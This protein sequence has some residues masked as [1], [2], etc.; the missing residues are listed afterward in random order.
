M[1]KDSISGA[2]L[3]WQVTPVKL[4]MEI[5]EDLALHGTNV[6]HPAK[7]VKHT[8][9]SVQHCKLWKP[10]IMAYSYANPSNICNAC[11]RKLSQKQK[12]IPSRMRYHKNRS[13]FLCQSVQHKCVRC[14]C[15]S[16]A[17]QNLRE[18][19]WCITVTVTCRRPFSDMKL[20][21]VHGKMSPQIC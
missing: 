11:D 10:D 20:S 1:Q 14:K 5:G 18:L 2:H 12:Q 16:A 9:W 7:M 21:Q 4:F 6:A 3:V 8:F 17:L 15:T 13:R 19:C